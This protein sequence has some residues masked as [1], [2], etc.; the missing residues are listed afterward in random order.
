MLINPNKNEPSPNP[1]IIIPETIP[2]FSGKCCQHI[3]R[4]TVYARPLQIPNDIPKVKI[5]TKNYILLENIFKYVS[6][7]D[8]NTPISIMLNARAK[9][10]E[11]IYKE[12]QLTIFAVQM[13]FRMKSFLEHMDQ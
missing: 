6:L 2:L 11:F 4:G 8:K 9:S 13:I 12:K 1:Q 7:V 5:N 3:Y 10:L